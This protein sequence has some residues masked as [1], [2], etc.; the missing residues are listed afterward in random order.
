MCLTGEVKKTTGNVALT[1][2]NLRLMVDQLK[3]QYDNT[4]KLLNWY[5]S[6][7][8]DMPAISFLHLIRETVDNL[9]ALWRNLDVLSKRITIDKNVI[10][11]KIISKFSDNV[12]RWVLYYT[13]QTHK[14]MIYRVFQKSGNS[15]YKAVKKIEKTLVGTP[16]LH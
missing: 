11:C 2:E 6:M 1:G 9:K 8:E 13:A 12:K 4:Q 3:L 5:M 15:N 16:K 10:R 14:D 7:L